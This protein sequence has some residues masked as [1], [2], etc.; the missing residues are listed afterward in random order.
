VCVFDSLRRNRRVNR[1]SKGRVGHLCQ[2]PIPLSPPLSHY[3]SFISRTSTLLSYIY[4]SLSPLYIFLSLPLALSHTLSTPLLCLDLSPS[5]THFLTS[6]YVFLSPSHTL[7]HSLSTSPL[8]LPLSPSHILINT[9]SIPPLCLPMS[10]SHTLIHT[11]SI[12]PLCLPLSPFHTLTHSLSTSTLCLPLSTYPLFLPLSTSP[13]FS[14][15]SSSHTLTNTL[16]FPCFSLYISLFLSFS[17][18]L[19][20]LLF[21]PSSTSL[22]LSPYKGDSCI[23]TNK[24][25]VK[26]RNVAAPIS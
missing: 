9:L 26:Q 20:L 6:L 13:L 10:S 18:P 22:S 25:Y 21:S 5:H 15:I 7:T 8:C 1:D 19:F 12:P 2:P 16:Y 24:G 11:L 3:F 17:L 4:L 14:P 23:T